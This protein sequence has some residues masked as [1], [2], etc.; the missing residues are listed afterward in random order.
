MVD[1]TK[2]PYKFT[3]VSFKNYRQV[4]RAI[5]EMT[6]RG[7]PAIGVAAAMD[8]GTQVEQVLVPR[9]SCSAVAEH[10]LPGRIFVQHRVL[11]GEPDRL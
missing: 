4:A 1:Q 6:V 2:L 5:E 3:Y 10:E 7:A 8:S 11:E 9:V